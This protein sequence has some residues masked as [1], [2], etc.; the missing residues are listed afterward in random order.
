MIVW[1]RSIVF[2]IGDRLD[3]LNINARID[4]FKE[5]YDCSNH[6]DRE[7]IFECSEE[8]FLLIKLTCPDVIIEI[9]SYD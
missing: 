5:K 6:N 8:N 4:K 1:H 7:H 9:V 2:F 3:L